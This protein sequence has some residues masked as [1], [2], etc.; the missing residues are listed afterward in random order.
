VICLPCEN[1]LIEAGEIDE[2]LSLY[3]LRH[4]RITE[5]LRKGIDL[6]TVASWVGNSPKTIMAFYAGTNRDAVMM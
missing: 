6:A 5:M 2:Y 1:G 3:H 4:T